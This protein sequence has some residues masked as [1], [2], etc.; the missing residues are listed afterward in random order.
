M[1]QFEIRE[2][3]SNAL[4]VIIDATDQLDANEHAVWWT[5]EFGTICYAKEITQ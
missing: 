5:Q 2:V 3:V 1:K 4:V